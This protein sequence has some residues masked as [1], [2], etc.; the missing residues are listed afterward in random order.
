MCGVVWTY[1]AFAI[2]EWDIFD[3][4][5][6]TAVQLCADSNKQKTNRQ[7]NSSPGYWVESS[8]PL[9]LK[10][11]VLRSISEPASLF[12]HSMSG[13]MN[14]KLHNEGRCVC[15][16]VCITSIQKD[17]GTTQ[18]KQHSTAHISLYSTVHT[19]LDSTQREQR[20]ITRG[21]EVPLP[22]TGYRCAGSTCTSTEHPPAVWQWISP[23]SMSPSWPDTDTWDRDTVRDRE[24]Q[25]HTH[26]LHQEVTQ[27][28]VQWH[29]DRAHSRLAYRTV[30]HNIFSSRNS[31]MWQPV[32]SAG[33]QSDTWWMT[34]KC[35]I[36][37]QSF[38]SQHEPL[39]WKQ[40]TQTRSIT[41]YHIQ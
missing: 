23:M 31:P 1:G 13:S 14:L 41:T 24:R 22:L 36:S 9:S 25:R 29:N 37:Q 5:S 34:W 30:E 4:V 12:L 19:A 2:T 28:Q 10:V 20:S 33:T 6:Q 17:S 21:L 26:R 16:C 8:L 32:S 38:L 35:L 7:T 39:T 3:L 27:K 40:T 18:V 15:V 11:S